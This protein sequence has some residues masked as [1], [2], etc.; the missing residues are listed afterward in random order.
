MTP[1]KIFILFLAI[2]LM[3]SCQVESPKQADHYQKPKIVTAS[4]SPPQ[5]VFDI[6]KHLE[7][8]QAL[9]TRILQDRSQISAHH[10]LNQEAKIDSARQYMATMLV[11]SIFHYWLGTK[12]SYNGYTDEPRNGVI[13]CGYFVS[14]T[15]RDL[16]IQLNRYKTAQ[17][18]SLDIIKQLCAA[19]S[20]KRTTSF[21]ALNQQFTEAPDNE[22]FIVGLDF[23]VGFLYKREGILY[24]AHSNYIGR[25]GVEIEKADTS[26]ALLSSDLY[27]TGNLSANKQLITD[28]LNTN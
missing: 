14:T 7:N 25:E 9:K 18:A 5:A 13:A 15:L 19:N 23:H 17:K 8:Y 16:G 12:W 11:D 26:S 10:H 28:W 27:F 1:I 22:I 24:F 6:E 4:T 20:V 3:Q 2:A 21:E